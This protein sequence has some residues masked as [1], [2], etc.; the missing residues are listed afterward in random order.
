MEFKDM[1]AF[2]SQTELIK[3][4]ESFLTERKESLEK[5]VRKCLENDCAFPAILYTFATINLLGSIRSGRTN[6]KDT[7]M[8]EEYMSEFMHYTDEQ[9]EL[10]I[11]I[12]RHKTTHLALPKD[13][14]ID[15]KERQV[16]WYYEHNN[17][18]IHLK[19][20]ERKEIFPMTSEIKLESNFRFCL[21]ILDFAMDVVRSIDSEFLPKLKES[22]FLQDNF[23]KVILDI[24]NYK[25]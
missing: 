12:W 15:K 22:V 1:R 4:A 17:K 6:N 7:E 16:A 24:Y 13:V 23:E 11:T 9:I 14:V 21:S 2:K 8:T 25:K 3:F 10:L 5:D 20:F 19:V 18:N